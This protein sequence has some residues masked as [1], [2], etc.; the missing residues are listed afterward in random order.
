MFLQKHKPDTTHK[1]LGV[2]I[3]K[4]EVTWG[5]ERNQMRPTYCPNMTLLLHIRQILK[6]KSKNKY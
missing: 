5:T 3:G 6:N 2:E 1:G 4:G